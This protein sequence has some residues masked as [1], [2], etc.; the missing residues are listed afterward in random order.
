M[1]GGLT[2][3]GS[4]ISFL[5]GI[6]IG[7][8]RRGYK[9]RKLHTAFPAQS[10][11]LLRPVFDSANMSLL[12]LRH[13]RAQ[14]FGVIEELHHR[15]LRIRIRHADNPDRSRKPYNMAMAMAP[16]SAISW[17]GH[18][19][20]LKSMWISLL[21]SE[22]PLHSISTGSAGR[23]SATSYRDCTRQLSAGSR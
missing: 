1:T 22:L 10:C 23:N 12:A 21:A 14:D 4:R 5:G 13:F 3:P 2:I 7:G 11:G 18:C 19:C 20:W 15:P 8:L 9:V 6:A 17:N 16:P